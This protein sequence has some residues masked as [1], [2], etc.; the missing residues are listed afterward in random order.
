MGILLSSV[1]YLSQ[2]YY[3]GFLPVI[4]MDFVTQVSAGR[5]LSVTIPAISEV[6]GS[7]EPINEVRSQKRGI[8]PRRY[9][10][11]PSIRPVLRFQQLKGYRIAAHP[12]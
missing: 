2:V 10:S 1:P 3:L 8:R 5:R 12:V 9:E 11:G 6:V 4:E 7:K